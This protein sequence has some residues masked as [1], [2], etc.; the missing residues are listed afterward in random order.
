M[1]AISGNITITNA[2]DYYGVLYGITP[3][4]TPFLS[5]CGGLTGGKQTDSV[6]FGWQTYDLRSAS[7]PDIAEGATAPTATGRTRSFV[8]NV[9]Q[10]FHE[11]I[12]MT[13]S[14][15]GATGQFASTGSAHPGTIGLAGYTNGLSGSEYD[16]QVTQILKQIARDADYTF[17]NGVFDEP[18]NSAT[19][20]RTRGILEAITTN[21]PSKVVSTVTTGV[22]GEADD[23]K[24][25]KTSHGL[26]SGDQIKITAVTGGGGVFAVGDVYV[27]EKYDANVFYLCNDTEAA[28]TRVA[29]ATDVTDLQ[30]QVLTQPTSGMILRLMQDIY[31]QGGI[32]EGETRTLFCNSGLRRYISKLFIT[33][34]GYQETSRNV[35]GVSCSTVLT[36]FGN[37]NVVV[38][39][40]MPKDTLLI[41]SMEQVA[42]V[43]L[44]IPPHEGSP[45]GFL[46][47]EKLGTTGS[48][49]SEQI[50]GEMGLEYG[51]E[52]NHG[53]ITGLHGIYDPA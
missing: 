24:F 30:Y 16:W 12:G 31:D 36:D 48:F 41:A 7:Q 34:K 19:G 15:M 33:D 44:L 40:F 4:D 37:L 27:I 10:I 20:R 8:Y 13:Y 1:A 9:V 49:L 28:A 42:P 22:T 23:E 47:K 25:T 43:H 14:K 53:K 51:Y 46:F 18:A 6:L 52:G 39:R 17:I 2:L 29:F 38:D 32:Q 3:E 35:G 5:M 21:D 11:T 45:G 26:L 50:Y